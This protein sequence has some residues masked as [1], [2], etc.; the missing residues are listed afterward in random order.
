MS[1]R[2]PLTVPRQRG[3]PDGGES[4]LVQRWLV[5]YLAAHGLAGDT[6][7]LCGPDGNP[8]AAMMGGQRPL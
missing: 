2:G 3:P 6:A 1:V 7:W 4:R 5:L 8:G